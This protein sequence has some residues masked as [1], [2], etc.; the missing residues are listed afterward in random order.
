M[1]GRKSGLRRPVTRSFAICS[2]RCSRRERRLARLCGAYKRRTVMRKTIGTQ[3]GLFLE[4]TWRLHPDICAFTS[5]LF[6]ESRLKAVP[7]LERQGVRSRGRVRGTGLRYLPVDHQG[8]QNS[9]PEEAGVIR[10]LVAEILS[11]STSWIDRHG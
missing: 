10:E 2:M 9:S 8:N 3:Q 11:S 7:G 4:D 5:E 1:P 6:Y